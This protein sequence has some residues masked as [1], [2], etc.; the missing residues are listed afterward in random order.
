MDFK[1]SFFFHQNYLAVAVGT[2]RDEQTDTS[3]SLLF[4]GLCSSILNIANLFTSS[5]SIQIADCSTQNPCLHCY[6]NCLG[7]WVLNAM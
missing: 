2:N 3:N 1:G 4:S 7:P 5:Q 6:Q